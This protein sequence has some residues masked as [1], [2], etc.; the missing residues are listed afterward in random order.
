MFFYNPENYG[1]K[2]ICP[3]LKK[4]FIHDKIIL[5]T[6]K[7]R[8]PSK[9]E[10]GKNMD[11]AAKD[12]IR[13]IVYAYTPEKRYDMVRELGVEWIRLNIPF[14]WNDRIGGTVSEQ[15]KHIKAEF[16]EAV[17]S[18]LHV[19]PST[20]TILGF[21]RELC[22]EYGSRE[23]YDNVRRTSAFMCEELGEL[24]HS[25][26]QCMNEL[27]IPTFSGDV[28]LDICAECCRQ[29]ALGINDINPNAVCGTNFA[30]WR[31]ESRHVGEI[32]FSGDHPFG[33]IGNDQYYGSWQPGT[34]EDW[35]DTLDD[36]WNTF[37]LPI[38]INEWGYSSRSH[39]WNAEKLKSVRAEKMPANYVC[40]NKAWAFELEGG[41]NEEIQAE[42]FRRGLEIFAAH[43]HV[44]G[45]F[46]FCFSD[47]VRCWQCGEENCPAECY[48]GLVDVNCKP[49]P[50][51]Y[52]AKEAIR[53]YYL[54]A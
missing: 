11:I 32:L 15:W 13:G 28:P 20:P 31:E 7:E 33:Y 6:R 30:S 2:N 45:N 12:K 51:F 9:L 10:A 5:W 40:Q 44:L 18:G 36:M 47:A 8:A 52:A 37:G 17:E 29:T 4:R 53:K 27:D 38:L 21:P 42:Y 48:W 19:M 46:M 41:H 14:P 39:T 26:W 49:K 50:A 24:A 54:E 25:L 16:K 22:G 23:F 1:I 3:I 35:N 34:I 43:P